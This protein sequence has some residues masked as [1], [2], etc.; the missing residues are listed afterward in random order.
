MSAP[1][2]CGGPH[3]SA[4]EEAAVSTSGALRV[5][6]VVLDQLI[7]RCFHKEAFVRYE[8]LVG[9]FASTG[10]VSQ[11]MMKCCQFYCIDKSLMSFICSRYDCIVYS[12][13][14][15]CSCWLARRD[16]SISVRQC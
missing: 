9:S 1:L 13:S 6:T 10:S 3:Y 15:S 5:L 14:V 12:C 7:V 2:L 8:L 11:V 16:R 4:N